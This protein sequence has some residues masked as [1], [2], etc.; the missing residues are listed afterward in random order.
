MTGRFATTA[1]PPMRLFA[2][3]TPT[4]ATRSNPEIAQDFIDLSFRLETGDELPGFAR[5]TGSMSVRLTGQ[6]PATAPRDLAALL[7]RM[8]A[9]AGLPIAQT[10]DPDA[11]ITVEFVPRRQ[12]QARAPDAACFVAPR[13]GSWAE[14]RRAGGATLDWASFQNRDRMAI[15]IPADVAPQEIRDCLHEELAQALGPL[16]DLY[17]LPDSVFNDDNM[18]S[19]LTGF[20]M[21]ILRATYAP[22]LQP[23][24][25]RSTVAAR[26]PGI[27]ARLNPAGEHSG[28]VTAPTPRAYGDA[29]ARALGRRASPGGRQAAAKAALA[30]S[31][32]WQDGR[33]GFAWLT[34]GRVSGRDEG[35]LAYGAFQNAAVIFRSRGLPLHLA[36]AHTQLAAFAL[37]QGRWDDVLALTDA[38]LPAATRGQNAA[39]MAGLMMLRSE[40]L[41]RAGQGQAAARL[42]LDSLGW[43]RYGMASDAEV[44]RRLASIAAIA[45]QSEEIAR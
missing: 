45:A 41:A 31:D 18:Q 24:M 9:E 42:R 1:L 27:L 35:D 37:A 6:V 21:L 36:H 16:N 40:A 5:F 11:A 28:G 2:A 14:Y 20:D 10:S 29:I 30:L 22:E 34:L 7:G 23:G 19:V 17:R 15:F 44:L 25:A 43:A 13:V 38:A 32:P 12:L 3:A 33:T 39:L 26:L 4:P 8:R